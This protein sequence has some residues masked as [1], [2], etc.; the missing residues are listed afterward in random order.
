MAPHR[1]TMTPT[2]PDTEPL[3]FVLEGDTLPDD[4]GNVE[5]WEETFTVV[6]KLPPGVLSDLTYAITVTDDGDIKYNAI[7]VTRFL[8]GVIEP[9]DEKRWDALI[10]DKRRQVELSVLAD[11]MM[12]VNGAKSNRPT[13]PRPGSLNGSR[14]TSDG[15]GADSSTPGTT[16]A[17]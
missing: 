1:F 11:V 16:P 5:H 17:T 2:D 9:A 3:Q 10:R 7:G 6:D 8:R 12:L 15:S 13:G 4:D 14:E